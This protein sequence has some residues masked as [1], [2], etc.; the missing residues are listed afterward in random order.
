MKT[1]HCLILALTMGL[2]PAAQ[3]KRAAP[4]EVK[5]VRVGG[6]EYRA[7]LGHMGCVEAWDTRQNTRVWSRQIYVVKITPDLEGDVQDVFIKSLELKDGML[8]I[9][10]ERGS[11]YRLD[12]ATLEVKVEKGQLV[13]TRR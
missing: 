1:V 6:I 9:T 4:E 10:N 11:E 13:E 8:R 2:L 3:A 12:P 7:P 5:P